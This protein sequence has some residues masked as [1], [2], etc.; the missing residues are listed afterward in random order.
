M[1]ITA[2]IVDAVLGPRLFQFSD[3]AL[4]LRML[5]SVIAMCMRQPDY[6]AGR[7]VEYLDDDGDWV[8]VA[9]D[10]DVGEFFAVAAAMKPAT[11]KVC[12]GSCSFLSGLSGS[13]R[14]RTLESGVFRCGLPRDSVW[15]VR[16]VDAAAPAPAL[17][18]A[19]T[20]ASESPIT[21]AE[22]VEPEVIETTPI[23]PKL[24]DSTLSFYVNGQAVTVTNPDPTVHLV[25]YLRDVMGLKAT[26]VGT[27]CAGALPNPA[28]CS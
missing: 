1:F 11:I 14:V 4:T 22:V 25:D 10:A 24:W 5:T 17:S 12:G 3:S 21:V 26:K 9:G 27:E 18:S 16:L 20:S 23:T 7:A 8:R 19:S 13:L 6:A 2:E 15:Q 28:N